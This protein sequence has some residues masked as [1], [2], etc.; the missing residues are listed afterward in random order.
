MTSTNPAMHPVSFS[1]SQTI[2]SFTMREDLENSQP[3][4][5]SYGRLVTG[6]LRR[7][8]WDQLPFVTRR[9]R[10][11]VGVGVVV[12]TAPPLLGR[13]SPQPRFAP[14]CLYTR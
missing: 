14:P 5:R 11:G 12:A 4:L 9:K 3:N 2:C 8:R 7:G 13:P 10:S 1:F 6:N